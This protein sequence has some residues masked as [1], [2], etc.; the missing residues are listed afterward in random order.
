V[1]LLQWEKSLLPMWFL[2][3]RLT[4]SVILAKKST[5]RASAGN[6]D[7]EAAGAAMSLVV[8]IFLQQPRIGGQSSNA[9]VTDKP[10]NRRGVIDAHSSRRLALCV[11]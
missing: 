11:W 6:D 1:W 2:L 10:Q 5:A 7:E 3:R 8:A 4:M 9:A